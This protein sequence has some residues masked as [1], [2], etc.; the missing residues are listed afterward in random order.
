MC[1]RW[2]RRH[3]PPVNKRRLHLS[4]PLFLR[5]TLASGGPAY[6]LFPSGPPFPGFS[7]SSDPVTSVAARGHRNWLSV[8]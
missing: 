6:G 1:S 7:R 2:G 3:W 5:L 8:W 4:P